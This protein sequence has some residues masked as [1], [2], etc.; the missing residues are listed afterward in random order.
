M[1]EIDKIGK[2][3]WMLEKFSE[4]GRSVC[5]LDAS[6]CYWQ[7][8]YFELQFAAV[9]FDIVVPCDMENLMLLVLN[10]DYVTVIL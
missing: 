2:I 10:F 6:S 5:R 8:N 9:G 4:E 1:R 7:I 3:K